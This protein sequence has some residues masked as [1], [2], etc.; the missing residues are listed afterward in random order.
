MPSDPPNPIQWNIQGWMAAYHEA[1][2]RGQPPPTSPTP[3]PAIVEN[4]PEVPMEGGWQ[5]EGKEKPGNI[6]ICPKCQGKGLLDNPEKSEWCEPCQEGK[7]LGHAP[8]KGKVPK[9]DKEVF[10]S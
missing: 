3:P 6:R 1:M 7:I 2:S 10:F 9:K 4:P 8:E 5:F